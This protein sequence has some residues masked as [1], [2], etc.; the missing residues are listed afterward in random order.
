MID[1]SSNFRSLAAK[2]YTFAFLCLAVT[3]LKPTSISQGGIKI[4]FHD[5]G[6]IAVALATVTLF[7]TI[8]ATLCLLSEL[9]RTRV[10]DEVTIEQ[11]PSISAA[12]L[13]PTD[14]RTTFVEKYH[15]AINVTSA[16]SFIIEAI[17]PLCLGILIALYAYQDMVEFLKEITK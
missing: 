12:D 16:A 9:I 4:E 6:L 1:V 2:I 13:I 14:R 11:V 10:A 8:S 15:V 3:V 17:L 7:L 5:T